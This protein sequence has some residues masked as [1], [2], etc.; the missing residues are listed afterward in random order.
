MPLRRGQSGCPGDGP[1]GGFAGLQAGWGGRRGSLGEEISLSFTTSL[2]TDSVAFYNPSNTALEAVVLLI[3]HPG[4][5]P[6]KRTVAFSASECV[7]LI[8]I[9]AFPRSTE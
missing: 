1:E 2:V 7:T 3:R 4:A 6:P 8:S 9:L 5:Q